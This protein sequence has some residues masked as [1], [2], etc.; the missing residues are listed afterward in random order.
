[1]STH[2]SALGQ[3]LL[4]RR[5]KPVSPSK[6]G[7][8]S[9]CPLRY[10]LETEDAVAGKIPYGL[11]TLRGTAAHRVIEKLSEW[12]HPLSED[13]LEAFCSAVAQAVTRRDANPMIRLAF[14]QLGVNAL[15]PM[16]ELASTCQFIRKI[17]ARYVHREGAGGPKA[18]HYK[19]GCSFAFGRERKLVSAM[20]DMEGRVDLMY[21]DSA[22][23]VHVCDFKTGNVLDAN[24]RPKSDY[25]LQISAYG[26]L[27]KETLGLNEA[28]LELAG[29][30]SS[31]HGM[32]SGTHE[33]MARQAIAYL[34]ARLPKLKTVHS[35]SLAVPGSWCA[36]CTVRP[37]C[38]TYTQVLEGGPAA[39]DILSPVD[40]AGTV[41]ELF[42]TGE[43]LRLRILTHSGRRVSISG[44]P[45]SIYPGLSKG[46]N[47]C[48]FSLGS[49]DMLA[50]AA[51]P[52]NFYLFRP[53]APKASAF[54]SL[55]STK[56]S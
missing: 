54:S 33:T 20:L 10:I 48:G 34:Q 35:E 19:S 6:L 26:L 50:R 23:T 43:F 53:D 28:A 7:V 5:T 44:I 31:W 27:A 36:S 37:T 32:L 51:F 45:A 47:I 2:L 21:K 12:P 56:L 25:L 4:V 11:R 41:T 13:L 18:S 17:L 9:L 1:M 42:G 38:P 29:P 8:F 14:E 16:G 52:A 3:G 49:Y 55:L 40:I 15:F 30:S 22:G 39:A 24:G 46:I